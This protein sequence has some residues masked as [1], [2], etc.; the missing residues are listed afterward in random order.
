MVKMLQLAHP[1]AYPTHNL[2]KCF[3]KHPVDCGEINFDKGCTCSVVGLCFLVLSVVWLRGELCCL[4][5]AFTNKHF[6]ILQ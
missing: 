2:V 3:G 4:H 6:H 5:V 1:L